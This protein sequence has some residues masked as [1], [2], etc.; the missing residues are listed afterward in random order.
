LYQ[1]TCAD[2]RLVHSPRLLVLT[3]GWHIRTDNS[4]W[5]SAGTFAPITR[6]GFRPIHLYQ[7]TCT[8]FRLVHS[9]RLLV[10]TFGWYVCTDYLF[11]LSAGTF[12]PITRT[13]FR[14]IHLYQITCADFRLVHSPRL[15]VLT[16]GWHIRT[17]NSFW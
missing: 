3:F 10:L 14:P 15:L 13:G 12:A 2:F 6:T 7:I 8:D 9:H 1:I 4:F 11:W 16:F 5:L 17:D